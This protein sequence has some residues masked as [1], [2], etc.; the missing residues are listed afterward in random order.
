VKTN[1]HIVTFGALLGALGLSQPVLAQE[2]VPP[3]EGQGKRRFVL[4]DFA[5]YSPVTALDMVQRIAGFSIEGGNDR[6]GFGD[7]AGNVLID[8]D[9]PSTKTDDIFTLLARIPASEIDYIELNESAGGANDARGKAQT[10]NVVRKKGNKTSG[11]YEAGLQL[12]ERRGTAPFGK[13]SVSLRGSR[14]ALDLNAEYAAETFSADGPEAFLDGQRRLVE[15]RLYDGIGGYSKISLGAAIKSKRGGTKINANM[16]VNW[17]DSTDFRSGNITS[18]LGAPIGLEILDSHGPIHDFGY[19]LG[20]DIEFPIAPNLTSKWIGLWRNDAETTITSID[21]HRIDRL[22]TF[23]QASSRNRPEEAI[24]RMQSDWGGIKDHAIQFGGEIALNRLHA[25]LKQR[26]ASGGIFAPIPP[27][28]VKVSEVRLE[29]SLSDVWTLSPNWKIEAGLIYETSR[30]TL[31]GDSRAN[32]HLAFFKPRLV[33]TWTASKA[34]TLEFRAEREVAQ[35][36]FGDFAT[37]VDVGAGN[38]VDAGNSDLV[39]EVVDSLSLLVRHNFL[40]RGSI[41]LKTEYQW[42][43]DTQ[44]LVP[45]TLRDAAGNATSRFDGSGN[46]GNSRRWNFELEITLPFDWLTKGL[47]VSGM[48]VK[49]VGHYHGSHVTDPITGLARHRSDRSLWHQEWHFRHDIGQS[50][51]AW[52]LTSFARAPS[53]QY[54]FDQFRQ[55]YDAQNLHIFAEYKKFKLGTIQFQIFDATR[56]LSTRS[57]LFYQDTRASGDLTRIVERERRFNRRFQISLAGKF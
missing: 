27:S 16:K 19:E 51:F 6:R 40:E 55:D 48:E 56:R 17:N 15:T 13:A 45:I 12:G 50:G 31:S 26:S 44:D 28:D 34:T 30:L 47:G 10:L 22:S 57:R 21:T 53:S 20:G 35:L 43:K 8:G 33:G 38:Q 49:Y 1:R 37:S 39:P 14:T 41:A 5:R 54:F 4:A 2:I 29:P 7:N 52:G 9:R 36:D 23:Y 18:N 32:R 11:T 42:V 24:F 3:V 25:V 46:I